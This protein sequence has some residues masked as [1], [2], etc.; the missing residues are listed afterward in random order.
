[1]EKIPET[2]SLCFYFIIFIGNRQSNATE[3]EKGKT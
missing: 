3:G 1:M 2:G